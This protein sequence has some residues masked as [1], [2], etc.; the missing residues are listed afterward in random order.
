MYVS[1]HVLCA[2]MHVY[3]RSN[4]PPPACSAGLRTSIVLIDA[5][6][7]PASS[8]KLLNAGTSSAAALKRR[9]SC[10]C[11]PPGSGSPSAACPRCVPLCKM[12]A[13][14]CTR[15]TRVHASRVS[16]RARLLRGCV[17]SRL[18]SQRDASRARGALDERGDEGA[19]PDRGVA[20]KLSSASSTCSRA[21]C[22]AAITA[23]LEWFQGGAT[24]ARLVG[25]SNRWTPKAHGGSR[26]LGHSI[27]R[28]GRGGWP[29]QP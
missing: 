24:P 12:S 27:I 8:R 16:L 18:A 7:T 23:G 2:C 11:A 28:V 9:S 3:A 4:V 21:A 26:H 10:C 1:M 19:I 17:V 25:G 15:V 22:S 6:S 20:Q 5:G 14:A 13:H 29:G